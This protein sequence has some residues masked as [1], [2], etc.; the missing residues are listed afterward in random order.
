[1]GDKMPINEDRPLLANP[2]IVYR[3][4]EDGAFLFDP[5]A[6]EL[7][8]LNPLG[9]VIWKLLDGLNSSGTIVSMIRERYPDI[10]MLTVRQQ[11]DAFLQ[12]LM[13]MGYAGFQ[14]DEPDR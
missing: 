6:G 4:E 8:C 3:E 9:S 2:G 14:A 10:P 13:D 1:M 12:E 7:K 5:D 11:V